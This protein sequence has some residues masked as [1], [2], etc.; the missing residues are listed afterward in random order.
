MVVI[1]GETDVSPNSCDEPMQET[2]TIIPPTLKPPAKVKKILEEAEKSKR[3]D[4]ALVQIFDKVLNTVPYMIFSK[5]KSG[6]TKK[7][8]APEIN[9]SHVFY[10]NDGY[11][12]TEESGECQK[13]NPLYVNDDPKAAPIGYNI[14]LP[15]D[16]DQLQ[17]VIVHVYG[18]F[19]TVDK[20]KCAY[21]PEALYDLDRY[22]IENKTATITLNLPD[23]LKLNVHQGEMP[24][25]LHKEIHEA[26]NHFFQ[27]LKKNPQKIH[28]DLARIDFMDKRIFLLERVLAA[29]LLLDMLNYIPEHLMVIF[30]IMELC[31]LKYL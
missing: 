27:I 7:Y 8:V 13:G 17:N 5:Y 1:K 4:I 21:Y 16:V 2:K 31:L 22:L 19:Q 29:V 28:P 23:L 30:L 12:S 18:G 25:L 11:I 10:N 14:H 20:E 9:L 6:E 15:S 26:I 24:E 3:K